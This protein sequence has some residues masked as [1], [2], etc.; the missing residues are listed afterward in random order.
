[1][2]LLHKVMPV[3]SINIRLS[4]LCCTTNGDKVICFFALAGQGEDSF[5]PNFNNK[6]T[7]AAADGYSTNNNLITLLN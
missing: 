2:F 5:T 7:S 3:H 4:W 1:M 6:T